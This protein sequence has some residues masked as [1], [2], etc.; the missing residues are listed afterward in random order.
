MAYLL[1]AH[2][3]LIESRRSLA[4]R[5]DLFA[6][7]GAGVGVSGG[8]RS[9]SPLRRD[10]T[11]L[12]AWTNLLWLN[13]PIAFGISDG[14]NVV[15]AVA[16]AVYLGLLDLLLVPVLAA[17]FLALAPRRWDY[18]RMNLAFTRYG[19]VSAA[20]GTFPEKTRESNSNYNGGVA[21]GGANEG[22]VGGPVPAAGAPAV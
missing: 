10:H 7:A 13:Y 1:L 12:A 8:G 11:A 19:R 4:A 15:G 3:T 21:G 6:T 5:A 20:P 22:L 2:N 18:G 17:A 9:P 16:G 14:G